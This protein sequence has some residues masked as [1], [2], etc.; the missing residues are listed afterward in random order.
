MVLASLNSARAK[1]RNARRV[2]DLKQISIALEMFY[3]DN[4][5][6]PLTGVGVWNSECASWGSLAA[7]DVI[8]G[9]VPVYMP[10]FPS[11]PS[12]DKAASKSC[13]LYSSSVGGASNGVD[14]ALLDHDGPDIDYASRSEFLDPTRD[15]GVNGCIIDGASYWSWK[16]SSPGGRCF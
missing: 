9:L 11:D 12:M 15:G 14:Y 16:V 10:V 3:D 2:N 8:P 7:N 5:N 1:A 4:G 13:Y 6:Y